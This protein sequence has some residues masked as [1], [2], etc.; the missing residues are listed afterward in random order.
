[1]NAS[2][3]RK[4][5]SRYGFRTED[6]M[7]CLLDVY[8]KEH[9]SDRGVLSRDV[10]LNRRVL[11]SYEL[12]SRTAWGKM[13][14][15]HCTHRGRLI[16]RE[17]VEERVPSTFDQ[18][19]EE[20]PEGSYL[21][22]KYL[23]YLINRGQ[24]N[25]LI[26]PELKLLASLPVVEQ[27]AVQVQN[28]LFQTGLAR[29]AH[30]VSPSRT[31]RVPVMLP[32]LFSFFEPMYEKEKRIK[33]FE[34]VIESVSRSLNLFRTLYLY[35]PKAER[36][37]VKKLQQY[38]FSKKDIAYLLQPLKR[39]GIISYT[40]SN[41]GSFRINDRRTYLR[42]LTENVLKK[43]LNE[44]SQHFHQEITTNPQ[45]YAV[46]ADF[47]E[48]FREFIK[49][50]LMKKSDSWEERIPTDILARL[51]ERQHQARIRKK[52]VYPLLHYIDFPNYLSII[53]HRTSSFNNWEIF[54]PYFIS[55]GWIKAR[56]IEM[57]EIRNDLAHPKPL[58]SLQYRKLQLYIDEIC[59]RIGM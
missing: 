30:P 2:S 18:L 46:L 12:L 44:F 57:N 10:S 48:D 42:F 29:K 26:R 47:E 52:Q 37:Y 13:A 38:N 59:N 49:E 6:V 54:E 8:I 19:K 11:E 50:T 20:N 36:I 43:A 34:Q 35:E 1:M 25:P 53:L 7:D 14:F 17:L 40:Y 58:E 28:I 27:S 22:L 51:K 45:A 3:L 23:M 16:G 32:D 15:Y 24:N 39:E 5:L 55:I 41:A 33:T 4:T 9:I 56:L 31:D 21:I